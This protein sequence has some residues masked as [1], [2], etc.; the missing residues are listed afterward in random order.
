M[1][2]GGCR[3]LQM[4]LYGRQD[5]PSG[6]CLLPHSST[7]MWLARSHYGSS[8]PRIYVMTYHIKS[9]PGLTFPLIFRPPILTMGYF[10]YMNFS[11]NGKR[12]RKTSVSRRFNTLGQLT[13]LIPF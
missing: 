4:L 11:L 9:G 5:M 13:D 6:G 7:A 2:I 1:I 3:V 10:S 8:S 12:G